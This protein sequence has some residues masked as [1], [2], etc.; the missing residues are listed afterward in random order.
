MHRFAKHVGENLAPT[1]L[2]SDPRQT[3]FVDFL[4][5]FGNKL[6]ADN[7]WVKL[8]SLTLGERGQSTLLNML[9]VP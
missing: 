6:R 7:R 5:P 8:V 2:R 4:S 3:E 1:M 9:F